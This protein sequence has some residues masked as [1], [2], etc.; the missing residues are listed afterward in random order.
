MGNTPYYDIVVIGA[1]IQGAGVAQ[2][3]AACG[4]SSLIIEKFPQAGLGTSS[5]SSKLIHG[6][7]RYLESGQIAL[8]K[9]CLLER[10]RLLKNAPDLV[11]LIPFYI[12]VYSHNKRPPWMIWL[13]LFIYS[14]FSLKPFSIIKKSQWGS[15]DNLNLK[16]LKA[17]FKYYDA[18]TDDKKLTRAVINSAIK[19]GA[20]IQ[21]NASF[22]E[23]N[24]QQDVHQLVYKKDGQL[25]SLECRCIVNC[26]GPWV[27]SIQQNIHP[28][29]ILPAID[30]VAG[31]HIIV[32]Y[33]LKHGIYYVEASDQRAVFIMPWQKTQTLIGTTERIYTDNPDKLG[34]TDSEISYLLETCNTY[35]NI[36]IG[37]EN[38]IDSFSG[39][40]VLPASDK[41]TSSKSRESLIIHNTTSPM[42]VTLIGG[43][44]T[45]Y[46]AS[47]EEVLL[48]IRKILPAE[49]Q[50]HSCD[51]KK[52]KLSGIN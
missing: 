31:S 48:Q 19:L 52:I 18:Q 13:G 50:H 26:S 30:L 16:N 24:I 4:Y 35:F 41:S 29:L 3:A 14:I 34:V 5:K 28:E 6:G 33:P 42:Q 37:R 36:N 47:S 2:A 9:E 43:K 7:L 38:I 27:E 44:L 40:R 21:Y 32:D 12:P 25:L 15:L 45:S 46:R 17:V 11:K 20:E 51:T 1:G 10:K 49:K 22:I 39:L 23:S 8:V